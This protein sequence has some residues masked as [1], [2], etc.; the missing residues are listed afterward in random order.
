MPRLTRALLF[1]RFLTA[2]ADMPAVF[3]GRCALALAGLVHQNRLIND[4]GVYGAIMEKWVDRDRFMRFSAKIKYRQRSLRAFR[5]RLGCFSRRLCRFD[6][7]FYDFGGL[8]DH[9]RSE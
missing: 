3:R 6:F 9:V 8:F 2:A 5:R 7:C 4:I 1:P